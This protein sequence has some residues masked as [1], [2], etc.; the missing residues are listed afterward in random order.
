MEEKELVKKLA[1]I[2][3]VSEGKES[4]A[5]EAFKKVLIDNLQTGQAIRIPRL[6][7]F[8]L[9]REPVPR[10][11]R[12]GQPGTNDFLIFAPTRDS[13]ELRHGKVFLQIPVSGQ[14]AKSDNEVGELFSLS[15]DKPVAPLKTPAESET[16][17]SK[18]VHDLFLTAEQLE[19]FD[20]FSTVF[21]R[22][23]NLKDETN[24]EKILKESIEKKEEEEIVE[25]P[26]VEEEPL[27]GE[28]VWSKDL[29]KELI[30]EESNKEIEEEVKEEK[31][32]TPKVIEEKSVVEKTPEKEE[33][34]Q[35]VAEEEIEED[36]FGALEESISQAVED[37]IPE[38]EI[39][40]IVEENENLEPEVENSG[41]EEK[42][43]ETAQSE[44]EEIPE[45]AKSKK[46]Y[47]YIGAVVLLI[48]IYLIFFTGGGGK[49]PE[50]VIIDTTKTVK[51][52]KPKVVAR[53]NNAKPVK[54][55]TVEKKTAAGKYQPGTV[56]KNP[57]T[58][59]KNLKS[60]LYKKV[61]KERSVAKNIYYDGKE[62]MVQVSS[63][64]NSLLA[65]MET[66]RLRKKGLDAFI[67]KA[68]VR[69]YKRNFFRVR[70]GGFKTLEQAKI[71]RNKNIK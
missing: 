13:K 6:G 36:P 56:V 29:E 61:K 25:E 31:A 11:E 26:K 21:S 50:K 41:Y 9:K 69:R 28:D 2:L 15:V 70:I 66:K 48:L 32:E 10:E 53:L 46:K 23:E 1:E 57:V 19:N 33:V 3:N 45:T 37:E 12:K 7:I 65:E 42:P 20:V 39:E 49:G 52:E 14:N 27:E 16:P 67:V 18:K 63:W 55:S 71:F 60:S 22:N 40:K 62:Y 51:T 54:K 47:Y 68:Y 59:K 35:P 24:E 34:Q 4:F 17:V 58:T 64:R 30:E 8:Q 44:E 5:F 38:E 43:L